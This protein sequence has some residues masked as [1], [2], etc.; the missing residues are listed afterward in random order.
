MNINPYV[1]LSLFLLYGTF[2]NDKAALG[3][4]AGG[5]LALL[6]LWTWINQQNKTES[7]EIK[8]ISQL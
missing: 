5:Y 8:T 7:I 4:V 6:F 1:W 3:G 2:G